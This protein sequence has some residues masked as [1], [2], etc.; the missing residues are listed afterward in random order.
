MR[1]INALGLALMMA[2]SFAAAPSDA[3]ELTKTD[4]QGSVTVAVTLSAP[5]V[6]GTPVN[7]TV[8]LDTHSVALDGVAFESAVVLRGPDGVEVVPMAVQQAKGS[9]HHRE[10]ILSF[11]P[12]SQAGTVQILVKA[13][14]G[15]PERV[16]GWE[17]R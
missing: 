14:G 9:G 4:R 16:F 3:Q 17:W 5:P 13:V 1:L 8:V 11:P 7:A 6:V 15:V 10:A 12:V 2:T